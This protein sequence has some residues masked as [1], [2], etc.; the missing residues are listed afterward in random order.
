[1]TSSL[2]IMFERPLL[3]SDVD[4]YAIN[5]NKTKITDSVF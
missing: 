5:R 3:R 2:F 1:M 4:K